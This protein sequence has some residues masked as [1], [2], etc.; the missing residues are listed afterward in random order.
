M[1]YFY[2]KF[3]I[4]FLVEIKE[5]IAECEDKI[6]NNIYTHRQK[7]DGKISRV[8]D[9]FHEIVD[10][11]DNT[12]EQFFFCINCK[13]VQHS[14]RLHGST[15]ELLRH[16]CV[17]PAVINELNINTND[18]ERIETAAAKVVCVDLRP[19][20]AVECP[21]LKDLILASVD[22]G[23]KYPKIRSEDISKIL[24]SKKSVKTITTKEANQAKDAIKNLFKEAIQQNGLGCTLDLWTDRFKSNT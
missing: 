3:Q 17:P 18:I 15:T 8:W 16:S 9:F 13:S 12:I 7:P 21:G 22:L 5:K 20:N 19:F 24:P 1:F 2:S 14:A 4:V 11:T 23:K 10:D 6:K